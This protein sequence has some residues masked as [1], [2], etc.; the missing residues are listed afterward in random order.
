MTAL[1][2]QGLASTSTTVLESMIH[3]TRPLGHPRRGHAILPPE[4]SGR[5]MTPI[6]RLVRRGA[7]TEIPPV[8]EYYVGLAGASEFDS[9]LKV[10]RAQRAAD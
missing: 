5:Q 7:A 6:P 10:R 8:Y 1:W 4:A 9:C 2:Q 3:A